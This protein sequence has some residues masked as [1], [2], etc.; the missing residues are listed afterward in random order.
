[1]AHVYPMANSYASS[2]TNL[3]AMAHVY[4]MAD[5]HSYSS[6][7]L[8]AV[9]N[10]YSVA[11]SNVRADVHAVSDLYTVAY[12]DSDTSSYRYCGAYADTDPANTN[13]GAESDPGT[14]GEPVPG[15][16]IRLSG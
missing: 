7:D 10:I 11:D 5:T 13:A 6:T 1:M 9:P 4:P 14:D 12:V 15:C 2:T 16:A 3:H 8:H